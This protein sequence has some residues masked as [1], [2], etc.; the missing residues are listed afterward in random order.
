MTANVEAMI[1]AGVEAYRAGKR[2]EARAL[3]ERAIEIDDYNE[4]AW[5]WLS[6]VVETKDE[7]RTCLEN[8]LV[9][10]PAN[11]R[12]QA[13]LQAL[14]P[15][16]PLAP[17]EP[18]SPFSSGDNATPFSDFDFDES[19]GNSS[20]PTEDP[21]EALTSENPPPPEPEEPAW[22]DTIATSSASSNYKGPQLTTDDYDDWMSNL[23]IGTKS[24]QP[25]SG[26]GIFKEDN[27]VDVFGQTS[28]TDPGTSFNSFD[29]DD[30]DDEDEP[31]VSTAVTN[32]QP[33]YDDG[34]DEFLDEFDMD[35]APANI[36]IGEFEDDLMDL[37]RDD[38]LEKLSDPNSADF[39]FSD[40]DEVA[41]AD[42]REMFSLIPRSIQSTRLPGTVESVSGGLKAAVFL[43]VLLN[44]GAIAAIVYQVVM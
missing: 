25:S 1:R 16:A 29:F 22:S 7:Q 11:E 4:D 23:N 3:L 8:V 44:V 40:D 17:P 37:S 36:G 10:N 12:A 38:S 9:I 31:S 33:L 27:D 5:L 30:T 26:G 20:T 6:A 2:I 39:L 43:L 35:D 21:F 15:A 18:E 32:S 42:P 14:G 34:F 19:E 41:E 13:G 24:Q 28:F